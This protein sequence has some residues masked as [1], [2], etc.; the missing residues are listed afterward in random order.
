MIMDN[1]FS[2]F[3]SSFYAFPTPSSAVF[4]CGEQHWRNAL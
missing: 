1:Q 2:R 4:P 3:I